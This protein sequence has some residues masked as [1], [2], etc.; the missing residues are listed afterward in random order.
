MTDTWLILKRRNSAGREVQI[1]LYFGVV[2]CHSFTV[3][4]SV[5]FS[6]WLF[7][8]YYINYIDWKNISRVHLW[9]GTPGKVIHLPQSGPTITVET[10]ECSATAALYAQSCKLWGQRGIGLLGKRDLQRADG[11]EGAEGKADRE[12]LSGHD[13]W[14]ERDWS[15]HPVLNAPQGNVLPIGEYLPSACGLMENMK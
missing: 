5:P 15:F 14:R 11:K 6:L 3:Y 10:H 9:S 13:E 1:L 4:P 8:F 12:R 7:I 2:S